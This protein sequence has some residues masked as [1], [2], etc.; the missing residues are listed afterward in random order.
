MPIGASRAAVDSSRFFF[1]QVG[2]TERALDQVYIACVF[3]VPSSMAGMS[4]SDVIIAINK[5]QMH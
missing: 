5:D 1:H 3:P 4:S 2:Q